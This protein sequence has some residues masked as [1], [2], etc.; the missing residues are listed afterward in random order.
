MPRDVDPSSVLGVVDDMVI[1]RS[2]R[3]VWALDLASG[4]IRWHLSGQGLTSGA[5]DRSSLYLSTESSLA[6]LDPVTG[7]KRWVRTWSESGGDRDRASLDISV[8]DGRVFGNFGDTLQAVDTATGRPVWARDTDKQ[9]DTVIPA[10]ANVIFQ[11]EV[12]QAYDQATGAAR[13]TLAGPEPFADDRGHIAATGGLVAAA[14]K[15]PA[16]PSQGVLVAGTDGRALWA[17]RGPADTQSGWVVAASGS[18]VFATD[19]KR[20][21]RFQAGR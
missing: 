6:A 1:V 19:H 20:L 8:A 9:F 18:S 17:H 2:S 3:D 7:R 5:V 11:E 10:G 4:E 21:Y 12:L 13:W 14:F 15:D 16:G